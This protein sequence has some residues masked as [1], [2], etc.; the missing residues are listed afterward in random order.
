MSSKRILDLIIAIPLTLIILPAWA[1]V[2]LMIRLDSRGEIL[3]RQV[4]VGLHQQTFEILK[5]R[6]MIKGAQDLGSG[7]FSYDNDPRI[8]RIGQK[9]RDWSFDETPQLI[10]ILRGNMSIVGPRPPVI[11]ELEAEGTLPQNY[12]NRFNVL[13]GI[14]GLAQISGRNSLSWNEKI[15]FDLA[16]VEKLKSLGII[17]DLSIIVKTIFIVTSRRNVIEREKR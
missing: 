5:F 13:P 8:T 16:Y 6:T 3:F 14:T 2:A 17:L 9:L 12:E 10:N 1:L 4:R 15:I 7:L 11:G